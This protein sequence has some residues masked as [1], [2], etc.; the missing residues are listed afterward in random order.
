MGSEST[1]YVF[2]TCCV[3]LKSVSK[4]LKKLRL[5]VWLDDENASLNAEC[6]FTIISNAYVS[7]STEFQKNML[8]DLYF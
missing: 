6:A 7:F 8:S 2:K 3:V 5:K 1:I 4:S